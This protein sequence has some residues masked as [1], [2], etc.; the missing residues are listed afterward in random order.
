MVKLKISQLN[1]IEEDQ[2]PQKKPL[3]IGSCKS[4]KY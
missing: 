2:K 3:R 1:Q 4:S